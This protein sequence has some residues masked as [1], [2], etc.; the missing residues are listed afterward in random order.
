MVFSGIADM[1]GKA[2]SEVN[3]NQKNNSRPKAIAKQTHS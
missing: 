1:Q 2:R 3:Y